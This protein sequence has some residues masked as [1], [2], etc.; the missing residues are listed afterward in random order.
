M[1]PPNATFEFTEQGSDGKCIPRST[2]ARLWAREFVKT[3]TI[4]MSIALDEELMTTWF[5]NAIMAGY[6]QAKN[7]YLSG[8]LSIRQGKCLGYKLYTAEG[9]DVEEPKGNDI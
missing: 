2:D 8:V 4:N 3:T 9:V 7:Q 5:A 6:D 1:T